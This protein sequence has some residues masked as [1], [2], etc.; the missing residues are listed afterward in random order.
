M[1]RLLICCSV[2]LS[3]VAVG[4][5]AA[6]AE[7][8]TRNKSQVKFEG[9]LGRMM[10]MFGGKAV[11]EGVV[12]TSA[13]KGDRMVTLNDTTG[14]IVDLAE[15]KVYE[16]DLKKKSYTV[17]TFAELRQQ[18]K[19]AQEKAQR[20]AEKAAKEEAGKEKEKAT[21]P[22]QKA[23]EMDVEF[24]VKETGERKAIAG[25]DAREVVMTITVHE[26]GRTI[27]DRG[28]LIV[29]S[30]MWLGP[31]IPAMRELAEFQL[32]Y[33]KAIAP[34]APGM[35]PEQ[36]ATVVAMYPLVKQAMDRLNR[37]QVNMKGTP[38]LTV[39]TF[40]A[41]KSADQI[42]KESQS[43][44]GGGLSG[45]MS[46]M[47]ARKMM[48]KDKDEKPRVTI[49]TINAETLEIATSVS[50]ADLEIPAGFKQNK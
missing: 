16:L 35:S 21:E 40:D 18:L 50:A 31:E 42:A 47:L 25:Y 23:P 38:L 7:V 29:A 30:D 37:E 10:G 32:R 2:A 8:K 39:T 22:D 20:D 24:D 15:E 1:K 43:S 11:K 45:G 33:W 46:G 26:K 27:E 49:F 4:A 36:L 3:L 14:R 34:E 41:V 13:V 6:Q 44:S 48:K 19:E 17:V 28:G 9:M 5:G 12:A